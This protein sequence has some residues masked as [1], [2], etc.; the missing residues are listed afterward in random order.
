M[1]EYERYLDAEQANYHFIL[2]DLTEFIELYGWDQ[3]V[4]D[5]KDYYDSKVYYA[6]N[7]KSDS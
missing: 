6:Q 7:N 3:V 2:A 1:L 4:S 5:L